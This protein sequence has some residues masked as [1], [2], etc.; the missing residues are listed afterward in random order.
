MRCFTYT[1]LGWHKCQERTAHSELWNTIIHLYMLH[2]STW[3]FH[4]AN[5][6]DVNTN[7]IFYICWSDVDTCS[8]VHVGIMNVLVLLGTM[9]TLHHFLFFAFSMSPVTSFLS[10]KWSLAH[11]VS[12]KQGLDSD[13]YITLLTA[14]NCVWVIKTHPTD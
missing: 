12:T 4:K 14:F 13:I 7:Q 6:D 3:I 2:I 8:E 1:F 9:H 11:T 10:F 5:C